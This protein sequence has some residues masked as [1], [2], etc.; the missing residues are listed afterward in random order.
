MTRIMPRARDRVL[1]GEECGGRQ[2]QGGLAH[3]LGRVDGTR[4]AGVLW[5]SNVRI[6]ARERNWGALPNDLRVWK[7]FQNMGEGGG[8][9]F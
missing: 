9:F 7:L 3:G 5:V 2:E 1:Y 4:V 8:A 6:S